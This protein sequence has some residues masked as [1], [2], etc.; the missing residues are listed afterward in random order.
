MDEKLK[1]LEQLRIA[2]SALNK[3][4]GDLDQQVDKNVELSDWV[5]ALRQELK[6]RLER[7]EKLRVDDMWAL[8]QAHKPD[9]R[10]SLDSMTA[11]QAAV[12]TARE[13]N[14]G[15]NES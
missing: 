13:V 10:T 4:Q 15:S 8:M 6:T 14:W 12:A 9:A 2:H 11:E 3:S 7:A 5:T 1:T